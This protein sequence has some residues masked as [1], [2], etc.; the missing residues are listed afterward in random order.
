M[1]RTSRSKV[2]V[3]VGRRVAVALGVVFSLFAVTAGEASA[4]V[5]PGLQNGYQAQNYEQPRWITSYCQVSVQHGNYLGITYSKLKKNNG[6]STSL[7]GALTRCN[8]GACSTQSYGG[9]NN[10]PVGGWVEKQLPL[11]LL[12]SCWDVF[13]TTP[14]PVSNLNYTGSWHPF[15]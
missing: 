4:G 5:C 8:N 2:K 12:S 6:W 7:G 14:A 1:V 9:S 13:T 11:Y 15:P 3:A 10:P